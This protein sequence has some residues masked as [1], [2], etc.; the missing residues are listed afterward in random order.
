MSTAGVEGKRARI[1]LAHPEPR[2]FVAAMADTARTALTHAGWRVTVSDLYRKR[3]NPVASAADFRNRSRPDY[4]VYP[5]EQRHAH[6]QGSLDPDIEEE[7]NAV[8]ESDLLILVFPVFWF[9]TPAILKG[10]IDRVF[11]SGAFYGGRRVYDRGGMTGKR[12]MIITAL[13]GREHMFGAH[14]I[15]GELAGGMLRHLQQG[16]L[17]YVG[18]EVHEPFI[19][20]HV[21]Y[22]TQTERKAML[23]RLETELAAI[24]A[25]PLV[26][27]PSLENFDAQ[28][29][30]LGE[31]GNTED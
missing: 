14:G 8:L 24:D 7:V 26:S 30:P 2:S 28:F 19:A 12:A 9:S 25:R 22:I 4:L 16:T 27:F 10:W 21:P 18:F 3:F 29:R 13:G 23:E 6:A 31:A 11:L 20:Y 1:V 5:L 17:G 15:H